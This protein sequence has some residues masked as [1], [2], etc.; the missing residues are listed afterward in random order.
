[1]RLV[2]FYLWLTSWRRDE[3]GAFT[4]ALVVG[5]F[6]IGA[7]DEGGA[8]TCADNLRGST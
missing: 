1:M 4:C 7:D 8:F 3:G 6:A 2:S 5:P